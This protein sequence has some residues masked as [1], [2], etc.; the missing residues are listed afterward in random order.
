MQ[1]ESFRASLRAAVQARSAWMEDM[2]REIVE[3]AS[4]SGH[5]REVQAAIRTRLDGL[6]FRTV[7]IAVELD[8]LK[9]HPGYSR[10]V[11]GNH[12]GANILGTL[13]PRTTR[14]R[15][16]IVSGHVDVVPTGPAELWSA[17]PFR[18][19]VKDGW[20]HGRGAG[21][22][23]GGLVA[24][25]AGLLALRDLGFAPAAP[26]HFNTV[27]EEECTGNGALATVEWLKRHAIR[28]DCMLDPE[29][30][31]ETIQ[32]AQLGVAWMQIT[33]TGHPAHAGTK[34]LGLNAI[35][36]GIHV[37][38]RLRALEAAWNAPGR[39]HRAFAE[40]DHPINFNLGKIQGGEWTSS[41]PTTCRLDVRFGFFPGTDPQ[42]AKDEVAQVVRAAV[43][44]LKPAPRCE[45]A[46][47]GFHAE[48]CEVDPDVEA[49]RVLA[50]VHAA[51]HGAPVGYRATT[52]TTD[53]RHFF[54]YGDVPST[55]YGPVARNVHSLDEAVSLE[56]MRRVAEVYAL[57][58]AE[59]C[60][61]ESID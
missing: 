8:R 10:P 59:W 32:T 40:N 17:A 61:L 26:F 23:K 57:F 53:V 42:V 35:E 15:S 60:S 50:R 58:I 48:G 14:G 11:P 54:L 12:G 16:L 5:E 18:T 19:H 28:V 45:I 27:V 31:G 24:A 4:Y 41:V 13:M 38:S 20:F 43:S 9:Q 29:P 36:A 44:E 51:A 56:S 39:R 46:F 34:Q 21:D 30:S 33:L 6:G 7:E 49:L 25:L 37:W 52:A 1:S 2:L 3:F 22:M 47:D 55:C